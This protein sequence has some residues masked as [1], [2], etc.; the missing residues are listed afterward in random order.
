MATPP[1]YTFQRGEPLAY[2]LRVKS[3]DPTG[4]SVTAKLK[5]IEAGRFDVPDDTVA[6]AATLTPTFTAA[7]GQEPAYFTLSLTA[8]QTLALPAGRYIVDE[9]LTVGG[10][11][12]QITD[13]AIIM[14]KNSVSG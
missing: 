2:A 3:G 6:V 11:S 12:Q 13:P 14:L 4:Y 9:K 10:V 7:A 8:V 1:V 5:P